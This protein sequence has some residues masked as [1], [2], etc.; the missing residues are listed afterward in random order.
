MGPGHS[1]KAS[2]CT[3]YEARS[4]LEEPCSTLDMK[5]HVGIAWSSG[6]GLSR[7]WGQF[8]VWLF[9]LFFG[10]VWLTPFIRY[11]RCSRAHLLARWLAG[12]LHMF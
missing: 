2:L 6:G 8:L 1:F 5:A 12:L 7:V 10:F 11:F 3:V 9:V 4:N